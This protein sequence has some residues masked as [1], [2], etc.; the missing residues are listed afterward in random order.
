MLRAMDN[1]SQ[2]K[3]N[4]VIIVN[5]FL[6][7]PIDKKQIILIKKYPRKELWA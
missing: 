2:I 4:V 7:L 5:K 3:N 1:E 6:G